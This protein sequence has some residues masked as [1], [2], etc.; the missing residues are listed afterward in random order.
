ML[1]RRRP[2]LLAQVSPGAVS[3]RF[4]GAVAAGLDT[5]RRYADLVAGM[6]DGPARDRLAAL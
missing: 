2:D 4:S 5:R 3:P 6:R 1:R